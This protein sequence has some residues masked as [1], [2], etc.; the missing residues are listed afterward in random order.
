MLAAAGCSCHSA[1]GRCITAVPAGNAAAVGVSGR[2]CWT[3]GAGKESHGLQ[4]C[5]LRD[6]P[7][8]AMYCRLTGVPLRPCGSAA[9]IACYLSRRRQR[10][11]KYEAWKEMQRWRAG[12]SFSK[13]RLP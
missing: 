2:C 12:Q 4:A 11:A 7:C 8:A 10:Q 1:L 13:C 6:P 9:G 3:A 5:Q